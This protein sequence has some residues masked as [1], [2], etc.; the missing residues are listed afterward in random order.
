MA[1]LQ[2]RKARVGNLKQLY[3]GYCIYF[4]GDAKW[5]SIIDS[6]G[7]RDSLIVSF[8]TAITMH[9]LHIVYTRLSAVAKSGSISSGFQSS[10]NPLI[11]EISINDKLVGG[12]FLEKGSNDVLELEA[13]ILWAQVDDS[14]LANIILLILKYAKANGFSKIIMKSSDEKLGKLLSQSGFNLEVYNS[15]LSMELTSF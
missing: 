1:S 4:A 6:N 2:L 7:R 13:V 3:Q 11:F 8:P 14:V 15:V 5:A 10:W 9:L 12:A